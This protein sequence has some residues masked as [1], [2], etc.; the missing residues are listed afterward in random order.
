M[1]V[2][3]VAI[4][5]VK[6]AATSQQFKIEGLP[7]ILPEG[8]LE[9]DARTQQ[10]ADNKIVTFGEDVDTMLLKH[11][12]NRQCCLKSNAA[13]LI[14]AWNLIAA[15]GL[16]FFSNPFT[17]TLTSLSAPIDSVLLSIR[18]M[19][20][21]LISFYLLFYPLAGYLADAQ[22]GRHKTIVGSL[23]FLCLSLIMIL[24]IGTLGVMASLPVMFYVTYPLSTGQKVTIIAISLVFGIPIILGFLLASCSLVA[25]S[26]NV[27]QYGIDQLMHDF[28]SEDIGLYICWYVWTTYLAEFIVNIPHTLLGVFLVWINLGI[29][30][31]ALPIMI[32]VT[33]TLCIKKQ[34]M[35][36]DAKPDVKPDVNPYKLVYKVIK[37]TAN[38]KDA[39]LHTHDFGDNDFELSCSR[40]DWGKERY[41]GPFTIKQVEE[42]KSFLRIFCILLTLGPVL[43][44]DFPVRELLPNLEFHMDGYPLFSTIID[45]YYYD[46]LE[47]EYNPLKNLISNGVVSPL[48]V[49]VVLPLYIAACCSIKCASSYIPGAL[50]RIGLGMAFIFLSALCTLSMDTY[51]HNIQ[52]VQNTMSCFLTL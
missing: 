17:G 29:L 7:T 41:G 1:H 6:M 16:E 52:R 34:W 30:L 31:I 46:Y 25:I 8:E 23:R 44:M 33:V 39:L 36:V 50:K 5:L 35:L 4:I 37:F 43:M 48:I 14:L 18:V 15:I 21:A 3:T 13:I 27:I 22:W 49:V 47:L 12:P 28:H 10:F 45:R 38:H 40:F 24:V 42:V 9:S 2:C 26:A 51:G 20:Y 19:M 11:H 32:G